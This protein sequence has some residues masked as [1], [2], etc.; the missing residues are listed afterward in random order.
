MSF[1]ALM[2]NGRSRSGIGANADFWR[3][4]GA[5]WAFNNRLAH[6]ARSWRYASWPGMATLDVAISAP[7]QT[8]DGYFAEDIPLSRPPRLYVPQAN[9][10]ESMASP[11]FP[12][13]TYV[14]KWDGP[15][16]V[17][18]RVGSATPLS[19]ST[20]RLEVPIPAPSA[21]SATVNIAI[22]QSF[23]V[24]PVRNIRFYMPGTEFDPSFW[25][26]DFKRFMKGRSVLRLMTPEQTNQG[27]ET[28]NPFALQLAPPY[29][30]IQW[31]NR[32]PAGYYA[33][34]IPT[35]GGIADEH[36]ISFANET[37]IDPYINFTHLTGDPSMSDMVPNRVAFYR[38]TLDKNRVLRIELSNEIWNSSAG[39]QHAWFRALGIALGLN[40]VGYN[41]GP[42]SDPGVQFACAVKAYVRVH[43]MMAAAI[44]DAI[45]D[46]AASRPRIKLVLG[47]MAAA[48]YG[49]TYPLFT[50]DVTRRML[51][52]IEDPA[53]NPRYGATY[54]TTARDYVD[55]VA[56]APYYG[57]SVRTLLNTSTSTPLDTLMTALLV[58][59]A[60][61]TFQYTRNNVYWCNQYGIPLICYEAGANFFGMP[62][63]ANARFGEMRHDSRMEEAQRLMFSNYWAAGGKEPIITLGFWESGNASGWAGEMESGLVDPYVTYPTWRANIKEIRRRL[64]GG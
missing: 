36:V 58:D 23:A 19:S 16:T 60:G 9:A 34:A 21:A 24:D 8:S 51:E 10:F 52:S 59:A 35:R 46:R 38:A 11:Y 30:T 45:G 17:Q 18:V 33:Q 40:T 3:A 41:Q 1:A 5:V 43:C 26:A 64:A 28:G 37:G 25:H 47:S 32:V 20:G 44:K 22:T 2:S 12:A 39:D 55:E 54:G 53:I 15:G 7:P 4:W 61:D 6:T 50:G 31:A 27:Q 48:G 56:I 57:R 63:A 14:C 62:T 42:T 13:G 49:A 29:P